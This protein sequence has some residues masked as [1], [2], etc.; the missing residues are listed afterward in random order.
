MLNKTDKGR[1]ELQRGQRSLDQRHRA[2]LLVTDG[3]QATD[4]LNAL[5]GG[6]GA[7]IVR[8]LLS[9]GYIVDKSP[10]AAEDNIPSIPRRN[11]PHA[12]TRS[13]HEGGAD[14]F[15]GPRTIAS[16]RMFLFD[17]SERLF[18][19][20][21]K[22]LAKKFRDA[23]REARDVSAMLEVSREIL[24]SVEALAGSARSNA[25]RERLARL[26]PESSTENT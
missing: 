25:I 18:A 6:L 7:Q 22:A 19:P 14:A 17:I 8:D 21:E 15:T 26:L 10:T 9:Q 16:A 2:V 4:S 3:N 24:L 23:L 13:A 11:A 20:R 12:S 1:A 5:F